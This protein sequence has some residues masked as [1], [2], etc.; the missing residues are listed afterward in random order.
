VKGLAPRKVA[1]SGGLWS[2]GVGDRYTGAKAKG[3][4]TIKIDG[5]LKFHVRPTIRQTQSVVGRASL[6]RCKANKNKNN[7]LM[8]RGIH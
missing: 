4:A 7:G 1:A 2:E 3:H 5:G 6:V 8:N